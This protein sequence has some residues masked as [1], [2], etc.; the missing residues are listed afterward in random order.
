[1]ALFHTLMSKDPLV[2][3]RPTVPRICIYDMLATVRSR[4]GLE[5]GTVLKWMIALVCIDVVR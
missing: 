1:M 5:L 2:M 3:Y 4:R